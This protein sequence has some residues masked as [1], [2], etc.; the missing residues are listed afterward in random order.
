MGMGAQLM[1]RQGGGDWGSVII[2]LQAA[3][4]TG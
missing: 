4:T 3:Q 1:H 2:G